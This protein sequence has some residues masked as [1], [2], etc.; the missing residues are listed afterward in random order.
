MVVKPT[1]ADDLPDDLDARIAELKRLRAKYGVHLE[2][3]VRGARPPARPLHFATYWR[4]HIERPSRARSRPLPRPPS[5]PPPFPVQLALKAH[6]LGKRVPP[7]GGEDSLELNSAKKAV[8]ACRTAMGQYD[9]WVISTVARRG[10]GAEPGGGGGDGRGDTGATVVGVDL[11]GPAGVVAHAD[12]AILVA[13]AVGNRVR[14]LLPP[15]AAKAAKAAAKAAAGRS[16]EGAADRPPRKGGGQGGARAE[17]NRDRGG[18][19]AA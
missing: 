6:L 5:P 16:R 15:D 13:E 1:T 8:G 7:P 2:V 14:A 3:R 18:H 4:C 17:A 19:G 10:E 12:G 9:G 11:N